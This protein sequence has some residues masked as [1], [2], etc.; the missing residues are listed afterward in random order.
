EDMTFDGVGHLFVLSTVNGGDQQIT[1][2]DIDADNRS[3]TFST[4]AGAAT[5]IAA[6]NDSILLQIGN[7]VGRIP[8]NLN[9]PDHPFGNTTVLTEDNCLD[10]AVTPSGELFVLSMQELA[11]A[12]LLEA[13]EWRT[14]DYGI[15]QS[16]RHL[17]VHG[18]QVSDI[19]FLL[20][21][22]LVDD[23]A[24]IGGAAVI[25]TSWTGQHNPEA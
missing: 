15:P 8:L 10:V 1:I 13:T 12:K 18:N 24:R 25:G 9:N 23:H 17:D 3:A 14:A 4:S 20:G 2:I 21:Q 5:R 11:G 6:G 7:V 16:V 19:D 22:I